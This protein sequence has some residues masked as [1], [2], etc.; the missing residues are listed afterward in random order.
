[1]S[2]EANEKWI[3]NAHAISLKHQN[4]CHGIQ[5]RSISIEAIT[6]RMPIKKQFNA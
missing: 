2:A 5:P 1:M 3:G 4:K 6:T